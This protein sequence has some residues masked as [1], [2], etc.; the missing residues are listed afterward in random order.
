M[1]LVQ[2]V[3]HALLRHG[4]AKRMGKAKRQIKSTRISHDFPG[5]PASRAALHHCQMRGFTSMRIGIPSETK[6]LE[7][8][9]AL[10]PA[11]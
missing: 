4:Q 9:V 8:R 5:G 10:V 3:A 2:R 7:G 6:I 11:A 1:N